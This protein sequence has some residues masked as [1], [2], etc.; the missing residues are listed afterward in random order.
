MDQLTTVGTSSNTIGFSEIIAAAWKAK[1]LVIVVVALC[2][3]AGAVIGIMTEKRYRAEILVS[4]A[5]ESPT[6]G[7]SLSGLSS[8]VGGLAALAGLSTGGKTSTF[9]DETIAVLQSQLITEA[10]IRNNDL[11]P[12]LFAK[13][14]DPNTKRWKAADPKK[15]PTLWLG[16][17]AFKKIRDVKQD[18]ASGLVTL[19][20]TWK[21]PVVAARWA[22][23]FVRV[24]NAY[25]RH[26]AIE[27]SDQ[28]IEY[29]N[30]EAAKTS[31]VEEK[32]AIFALLKDEINKQM[33]AKGRE[34][35]ALKVLDPAEIPERPSTPAPLLIAIL[36]FAVG[37]IISALYV[38]QRTG[39]FG[40]SS[41]S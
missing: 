8:Q 34:E 11:L 39:M 1:W 7:G 23:D 9:R 15:V 30:A 19:Q 35:Y 2:T 20:I 16:A 24:T 18:K 36:G 37:T 28:N 31:M 21:D 25:L 33:I 29:L 22:N 17:Q 10:Y 41:P 4:P 13:S 38:L 40:N 27:E 12:V 3:V 26:R 14:W 32:A 6:G 5:Q